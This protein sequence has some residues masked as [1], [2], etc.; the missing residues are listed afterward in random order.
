MRPRMTVG[1]HAELSD[2]GCPRA[3]DF[4]PPIF[5]L[6]IPKIFVQDQFLRHSSLEYDAKGIGTVSH[7]LITT[8]ANSFSIVDA[9]LLRTR[10]GLSTWQVMNSGSLR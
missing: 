5:L 1:K 7:G 4:L 2:P 6:E 9:T 8:E 3:L 10:T